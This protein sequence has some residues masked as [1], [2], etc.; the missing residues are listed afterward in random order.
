M[1]SGPL[2]VLTRAK[3]LILFMWSNG[4]FWSNSGPIANQNNIYIKQM[5]APC[6]I[7]AAKKLYILTSFFCFLLVIIFHF[8]KEI[9]G[10]FQETRELRL[11]AFWVL[12]RYGTKT[13]HWT[14]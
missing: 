14:N 2:S 13:V 12:D 5:V 6:P 1:I 8:F 3:C 7:E 4:P 10:P 9:M 11:S